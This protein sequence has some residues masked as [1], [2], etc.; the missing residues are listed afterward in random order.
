M[1]LIMA[2]II[3]III[4][5]AVLFSNW[6]LD[7]EAHVLLRGGAINGQ[8]LQAK[9]LLKTVVRIQE[10]STESCLAWK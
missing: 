9:N 2:V 8:I 3:I 7:L 6:Q 10:G 4:I 5:V 1:I